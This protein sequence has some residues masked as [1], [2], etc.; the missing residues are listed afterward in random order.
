MGEGFENDVWQLRK[1]KGKKKKREREN[2]GK[3]KKKEKKGKEGMEGRE[4]G[5][6]ID[7]EGTHK[8]P[9]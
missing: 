8:L 2:E 6:D 5:S 4:F 3:I 7:V 9:K 1:W